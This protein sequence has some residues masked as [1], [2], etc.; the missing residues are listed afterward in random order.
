MRKV[1][2]KRTGTYT[3]VTMPRM[4]ELSAACTMRP[5][6]DPSGSE[7]LIDGEPAGEDEPVIGPSEDMPRQVITE[8]PEGARILRPAGLCEG[9]NP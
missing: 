3:F 6:K 8:P 5:K 9:P 2:G 1:R 7:G 4:A